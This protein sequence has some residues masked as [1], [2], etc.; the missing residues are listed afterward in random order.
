MSTREDCRATI[1]ADLRKLA[2][3]NALMLAIMLAS[4]GILAATCAYL[5]HFPA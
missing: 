5:Y 1:R 3:L 4:L 2:R